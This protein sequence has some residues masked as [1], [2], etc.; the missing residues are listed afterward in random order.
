M[1]KWWIR[2]SI[3]VLAALILP[4]LVPV[5]IAFFVFALPSGP[6][7]I[8]CPK[9]TCGEEQ[10]ALLA[11]QFHVD[12]GATHFI[13]HFL[14]QAIQGD[15][16]VSWRG[17]TTGEQ[18]LDLIKAALPNS[19]LALFI[20]ILFIT[21]GSIAGAFNRPRPRWDPLLLIISIVPG[22]V[23]SLSAAAWIQLNYATEEEIKY[24]LQIIVVALIIGVAD[25]ALSSAVI[26]VR[27][28]FSRENNQRYVGVGILRGERVLSNTLP[29]LATTIAGQYRARIIHLLSG[30]IVAEV[31]LDV[32][33]I[34]ALL[35]DGTLVQDFG[36]V[37][38]TASCFACISSVL[39]LSQALIEV[40]C[41]MHIRRA[42][43]IDL[44][45]K[46][47]GAS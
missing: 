28:A 37:L 43:K 36:R 3:R 33:G 11:K 21:I 1:K 25:S 6:A 45:E 47:M 15:L 44:A 7:E 26:G 13:G 10:Y 39:L 32:D 46:S 23:L 42:P 34:G 18:N 24:R 12:Q 9:E 16:G 38:A 20:G 2:P 29:N 27:G 19:L 31:V 40:S 22:L 4:V 30:L 5:V 41:A 14:G 17:V 35:W 8:I